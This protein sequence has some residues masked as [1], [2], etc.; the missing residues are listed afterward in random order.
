MANFILIHGSWCGK[1]VWQPIIPLLEQNGHKVIAPDLPGSGEDTTPVSD[2]TMELYVDD[3]TQLIIEKDLQDIILVGHSMGGMI[4][5]AVAEKLPNKITTLVY[6]TAIVPS[7]GKSFVDIMK[8]QPPSKIELEFTEDNAIVSVKPHVM[9]YV[10]CNNCTA[11]DIGFI[12][13]MCQPTA[14]IISVTPVI[15]TNDN[16][17]R[18]P[19]IFIECTN[20]NAIFIAL[21]RMMIANHGIVKIYSLDADHFPTFSAPVPLGNALNDIALATEKAS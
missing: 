3:I 19:R 4:I 12:T 15:L 10:F 8:L 7:S 17:G 6:L 21:Q 5:S 18:V 13:S 9:S 1:W 16:Y 14:S 2:V 11:Q 20:D